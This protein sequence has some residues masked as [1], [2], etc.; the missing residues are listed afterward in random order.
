MLIYRRTIISP[1][2]RASSTPPHSLS[3]ITVVGLFIYY[4]I[5]GD[6]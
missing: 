3:Y 6:V 4:S 1:F 5:S 2:F